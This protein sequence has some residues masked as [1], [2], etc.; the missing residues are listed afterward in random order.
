MAHTSRD[1]PSVTALPP[2]EGVEFAD[3]DSLLDGRSMSHHSNSEH[4]SMPSEG[5][6]RASLTDS[7]VSEASP[8]ATMGLRIDDISS[9][10]LHEAHIAL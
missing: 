8:F 6:Q 7:V 5:G 3:V 1:S 10:H 4:A 2:D 9:L